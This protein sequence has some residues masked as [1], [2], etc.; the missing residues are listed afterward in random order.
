MRVGFTNAQLSE[1]EIT[2][3]TPGLNTICLMRP[4]G[5]LPEGVTGVIE[6]YQQGVYHLSLKSASI[7][8]GFYY[9]GLYYN[10]ELVHFHE[11]T[12]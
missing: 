10:D 6:N 12:R 9:F 11:F 5:T 4:D 8:K 3:N 7:P 1:L 2:I